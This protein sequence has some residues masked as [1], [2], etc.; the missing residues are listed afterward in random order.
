MRLEFLPTY[1]LFLIVHFVPRICRGKTIDTRASNTNMVRHSFFQLVVLITS[2]FLQAHGSP[3]A[4]QIRG[5]CATEDPD[6]HFLNEIGRMKSSEAN[7]A[8]TTQARRAPVE[9]G[10]WFHIVSSKAESEQV[11][12]D[13]VDSQVRVLPLRSAHQSP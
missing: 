3:L 1:S 8:N 2:L 11:T 12:D 4:Q 13:M 5:A 10:T 7:A 9:I 6:E